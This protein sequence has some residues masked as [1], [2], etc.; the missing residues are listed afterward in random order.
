MPSP[1]QKAAKKRFSRAVK[2][3]NA[4]SKVYK[5]NHSYIAFIGNHIRGRLPPVAETTRASR[6]RVKSMPRRKTRKTR[7]V[8]RAKPRSSRRKKS[9]SGLMTKIKNKGLFGAKLGFGV[10]GAGA[11]GALAAYGAER[12]LGWGK[13]GQALAGLVGGGPPGALAGY[14]QREIKQNVSSMTGIPLGASN[15]AGATEVL[16]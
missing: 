2:A 4:K 1:K 8:Y 5:A 10:A 3:W 6:S 15:G 12:F 7:V 13:N 9:R 14:F 16:G 11:A